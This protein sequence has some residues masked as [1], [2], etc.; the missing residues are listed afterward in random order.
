MRAVEAL[1]QLGGFGT[2]RALL[3][4]GVTR[5]GLET[6]LRSGHLVRLQR[7]VYGLGLPEG[8]DVTRA[9]AICLRATVSHDSAALLWGMEMVHRPA[10]RVTVGRDHSR[11]TYPGVEVHRSAV[12]A[13]V[14]RGVATTDPLRTVLDCARVL[15]LPDA[16]VVADSALRRGLVGIEELQ[17]AARTT[18]GPGA[19]RVRRAVRLADPASGSVLESLLR[20]LLTLNGLAPP[21]TQYELREGGQVQARVDFAWPREKLI[22]EADGFAY[23]RDRSDYRRDRRRANLCCRLGWRLLRFSWEDVRHDP[24]YVLDAVRQELGRRAA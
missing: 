24:D 6:A 18:S 14:V 7:G 1:D 9:A 15:D 5:S 17:A 8:W 22:V 21:R 13:T 20:V 10:A 19:T 23:H 16:V 4:L 3:A 11:R 2:R 12:R